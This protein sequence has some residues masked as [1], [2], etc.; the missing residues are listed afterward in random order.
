[1]KTKGR[2]A[3]LITWEGD[4]FEKIGRPKVVAALPPQLGV[5]KFEFILELLYNSEHPHT[6]CDKV[7]WG[8]GHKRDK[9]DYFRYNYEVINPELHY[10]HP[11]CFLRARVVKNLVCQETDS[12]PCECTL[13]WTELAK[14]IFD[15]SEKPKL[16]R[17]ERQ[18]GYASKH[19]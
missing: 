18:C 3:W 17:E 19:P 11:H 12:Y 1:M 4:E 13:S 2:R 10:G 6:L 14:Y 8:L 7:G 5:N 15:E 16:V 9:P